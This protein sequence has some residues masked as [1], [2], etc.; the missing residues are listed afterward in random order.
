MRTCGGIL[1][2]LARGDFLK[3]RFKYQSVLARVR[4]WRS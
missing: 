3:A 1:L 4:G 2:A